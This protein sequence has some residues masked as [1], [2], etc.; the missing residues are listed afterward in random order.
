[1]PAATPV[2]IPPSV[3]VAIPVEPLVQVP[4]VTD[5]TSVVVDAEQKITGIEG[6]M[7]DGVPATLT[8]S[9]TVQLPKVYDIIAIL[10]ATPLTTPP[11][12]TVAMPVALLLQ[13][14]P[15]VASVND[16]VVPLQ[17]VADDGEI[18]PGPE[19]TTTDS[20]AKQPPIV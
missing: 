12:D 20:I 16:S 13:V 9:V 7:T 8:I 19:V 3:T 2:T 17:I 15:E 5:S 11:D 14:P 1:M 6:V 4:P 18:A 10:A